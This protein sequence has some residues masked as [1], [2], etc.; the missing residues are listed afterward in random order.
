MEINPNEPDYTLTITQRGY[1]WVVCEGAQEI[2]R[3]FDKIE[4]AGRWFRQHA[5]WHQPT[6]CGCGS[7]IA[8]PDDPWVACQVSCSSGADY[9]HKSC[10]VRWRR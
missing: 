9:M 6:C 4:E 7:A 8:R 2:S 10:M 1:G 5:L 3:P